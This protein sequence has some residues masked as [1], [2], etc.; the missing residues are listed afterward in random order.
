M[1]FIG[2]S[3]VT[4]TRQPLQVPGAMCFA[5]SFDSA[6]RDRRALSNS[7]NPVVLIQEAHRI[8]RLNRQL[9]ALNQPVGLI[10]PSLDPLLG[11]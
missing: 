9:G 3:A 7:G 1:G 8:A 10:H 4:F 2:N 6:I 5:D 11:F